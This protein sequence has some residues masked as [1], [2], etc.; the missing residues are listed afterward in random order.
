MQSTYSA[1]ND[2]SAHVMSNLLPNHA[3]ATTNKTDA[4]KTLTMRGI[5][6][7]RAPYP[8]QPNRVKPANNLK[9]G[10]VHCLNGR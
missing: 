7:Y 1:A 4:I 2:P 3:T 9:L 8:T 5:P 6:D 10:F